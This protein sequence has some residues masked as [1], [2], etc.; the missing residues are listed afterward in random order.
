MT[1]KPLDT[2]LILKHSLAK[3]IVFSVAEHGEAGGLGSAI[4][5][6]LSQQK[7]PPRLKIISTGREFIKE[8][9]SQS[10]LR[11][12]LGLTAEGLSKTIA[13]LS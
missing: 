4:A 5:E 1:T 6:L 11:K 3:K 12:R 8:L 2:K 10:Y 7:N 13:S 9:G